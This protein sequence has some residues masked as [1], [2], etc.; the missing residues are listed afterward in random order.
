MAAGRY[1]TLFAAYAIQPQDI[2]LRLQNQRLYIAPHVQQYLVGLDAEC[3]E[4][5]TRW[6]LGIRSALEAGDALPSFSTAMAATPER[7]DRTPEN[8]PLHTGPTE[9]GGA[10]RS[11]AERR[12]AA[13][14]RG[15]SP[16]AYCGRALEEP[17][18][19][20]AVDS[21]W[22]LFPC[23]HGEQVH[24]RCMLDR[25]ERLANG[26]AE[27]Q[28]CVACHSVRP[29]KNRPLH[30]AELAEDLPRPRPGEKWPAAARALQF[31]ELLEED[32]PLLYPA[33]Y[34]TTGSH[35]TFE[36]MARIHGSSL[37]SSFLLC[38]LFGDALGL[39]QG[40]YLDFPRP[41][42]WRAAAGHQREIFAAYDIRPQDTELRLPNRRI[43][44][45][46]HVQEFLAGLDSTWKDRL[47]RWTIGVRN[48]LEKGE[49]LPPFP[50]AAITLGSQNGFEAGNGL[51]P[52]PTAAG[53]TSEGT[54]LALESDSLAAGVTQPEGAA[55]ASGGDSR[56]RGQAEPGGAAYVAVENTLMAEQEDFTVAGPLP[57]PLSQPSA[58]PAAVRGMMEGTGPA[59]ES[60]PSAA[61]V[62]PPEGATSV[63]R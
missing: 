53:V 59:R 8:D 2:L 5:L 26:H 15:A 39:P 33:S 51:P 35:D 42:E 61:G 3:E 54:D 17:T 23:P 20:S 10:A 50:T 28:P 44:I 29:A 40:A 31:A 49:A 22:A 48:A 4:R 60:D 32:G 34:V 7:T 46:P 27:P 25:A 11:A 18:G 52:S 9:Q 58:T 56:V 6:A 1:R 62:A 37:T 45:L 12:H 47:T 16:C 24:A 14:S 19:D 21:L 36:E 41:R 55:P 13:G 43:Y 38:T 63:R 30:Q 57:P